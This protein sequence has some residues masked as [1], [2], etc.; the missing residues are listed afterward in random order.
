MKISP[1]A[2]SEITEASEPYREEV[3]GARLT[4]FTKDAY[5]RHAENFVRWLQD[6]FESGGT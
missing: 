5:L 2:L 4:R 3:E 6:D 1:A